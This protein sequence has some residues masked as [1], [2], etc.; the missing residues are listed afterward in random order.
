MKNL[1]FGLF[2]ISLLSCQQEK[3]YIIFMGTIT[4]P[5]DSVCWISGMDTTA[6]VSLTKDGTFTDTLRIPEGYYN[7]HHRERTSLYL[8]HGDVIN[9][10]IDV[11]QF[12]ETAA[13][14]GEGSAKNNYLA[15][16]YLLEE[17]TIDDYKAL[18]GAEEMSFL[19]TMDS[20]KEAKI[21]LLSSYDD[22]SKSFEQEE[23]T[24]LKY[25]RLNLISNYSKSHGYYSG[26]QDYE[27][28]EKILSEFNGED[29]DNESIYKIHWSYR[30]LVHSQ[31]LRYTLIHQ[32]PDTITWVLDQVKNVES[33]F[34]KKDLLYSL[35]RTFINPSNSALTKTY[36]G[37]MNITTDENLKDEVT[38]DYEKIKN[39][40]K[41]NPS[42]EFSYDD[43]NGNGVALEDF[44]GKNVYIDVWATWCGPCI[45][46]IPALKELEEVYND[47]NVQFVSISI[48]RK[49]DYEKWLKMIEEKEL[50]GVQLFAGSGWN[51]SI[52]KDYVIKGIPRFILLDTQGKIVSA[53]APR[54]SDPRI[55]E[56]LDELSQNI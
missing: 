20:V 1:L 50:G 37:I 11:E 42:P 39:L 23:L 28:S 22:L 16:K 7:F 3:N 41:G 33:P 43:Q 44:A 5:A 52:V 12:D 34:I 10:T 45:Q 26:Q 13:Y 19:K 8:E 17:K 24:A 47:Q 6:R 54:P 35:A 40:A 32:N 9:M 53:D 30:N 15:Q 27:P 38:G 56:M 18:Y 2:A 25:E 49:Q 29:Y 46:E 36:E 31:Y 55:R 4:N 51:A 48:D 14:T 21:E